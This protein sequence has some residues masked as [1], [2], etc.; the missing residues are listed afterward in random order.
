MTIDEY[1]NNIQEYIK[2][3]IDDKEQ[4][5]NIIHFLEKDNIQAVIN[6]NFNNKVPIEES[7]DDILK[8]IKLTLL[9]TE[10]TPNQLTGERG[11]NKMEKK[12]MS[13][14]DFINESSK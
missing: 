14:K 8:Q 6:Q 3:K 2:Q 13:F 11:L 12:I 1:F 10:E 9:H 5:N 4:I 7:G